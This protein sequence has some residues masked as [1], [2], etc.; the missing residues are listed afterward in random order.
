M[1]EEQTV[2]TGEGGCRSEYHK[3]VCDCIPEIIRQN[4]EDCAPDLTHLE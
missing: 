1:E 3:L 4:G 2:G